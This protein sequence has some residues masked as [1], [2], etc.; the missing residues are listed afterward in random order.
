[1]DRMSSLMASVSWSTAAT[2]ARDIPTSSVH[3]WVSEG[4]GWY[5]TGTFASRSRSAYSSLEVRSGSKPAVA[6]M[7]G[8][9]FSR[10]VALPGSAYGDVR[11]LST[12]RYQEKIEWRFS[13][14]TPY[15]PVPKATMLGVL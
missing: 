10:D 1:M 11:A 5:V 9:R 15:S 12:G 8:G 7:A 3:P 13:T 6:T 2:A 14:S 4:W